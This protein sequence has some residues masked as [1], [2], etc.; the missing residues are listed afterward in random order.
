MIISAARWIAWT[1]IESGL[2]DLEIIRTFK[3]CDHAIEVAAALE[4]LNGFEVGDV[5]VSAEGVVIAA[6][7]LTQPWSALA[8]SVA[9]QREMEDS[10]AVKH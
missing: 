1:K 5:T 8:Q 7:F 9:A 6:W 3:P 10:G 2:P 4:G